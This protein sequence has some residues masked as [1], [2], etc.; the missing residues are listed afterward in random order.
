G[1]DVRGVGPMNTE[2]LE[3]QVAVDPIESEHRPRRRMRFDSRNR[4][5]LRFQ[6]VRDGA[7]RPLVEI[8][9]RDSRLRCGS[10]NL[11]QARR[12]TRALAWPEAEMAHEHVH[13]ADL[14][15]EHDAPLASR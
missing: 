1:G 6:R 8:A 5:E 10:E 4:A 13:P 3:R 12:L 15:L 9:E 14:R 11:S 7:V 2:R